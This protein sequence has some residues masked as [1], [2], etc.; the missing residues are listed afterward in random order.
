MGMKV[1]CDTYDHVTWVDIYP[2]EID[3]RK[4]PNFHSIEWSL[5]HIHQV[6][7]YV[8]WMEYK[9]RFKTEDEKVMFILKW[10]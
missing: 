5:R 3:L 4:F 9:L 1:Y 6:D 7:F 2:F 10:G 8:D